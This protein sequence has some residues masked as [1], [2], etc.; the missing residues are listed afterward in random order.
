MALIT[1]SGKL[2]IGV[3]ILDCDHREMADT[4]NELLTAVEAD[5]DRSLTGPLLRK[6]AHFTMTH[7]ALEEGM[8]QAT[9]YP[10]SVVHRLNHK[11]LIGE[12]KSLVS[13]HTQEGKALNPTALN[14]LSEWHGDHLQNDDLHYGHWLNQMGR[15]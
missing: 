2:S 7:F 8:M 4:I 13:R 9:K 1:A 5:Q 12:L 6:L 14:F 10:G 11:R 15:R 3:K